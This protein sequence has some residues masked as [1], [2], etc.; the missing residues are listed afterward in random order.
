MVVLTPRARRRAPRLRLL[1][2]VASWTLVGAVGLL[3]VA[4]VLVPRS[5]GATSYVIESGSMRP[6]LPPGTLVVVRPAQ[7][8]DLTIGDVIT[9]ERGSGEIVTHRIV[10][11]KSDTSG[12]PRWRTQGDA[13]DSADASWVHPDQV[14]GKR[15]YTLPFVGNVV[16]LLDGPVRSLLLV[17]CLLGLIFYASAM[18]R[19]HRRRKEDR[20]VERR[21][22]RQQPSARSE[23]RPQVRA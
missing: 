15:W 9:F 18:S 13:N 10:K 14:L 20:E 4:V 6:T 21:R 3:L 2:Q 5:T 17:A 12:T 16:G 22:L 23:S 19:D 1:A 11:E 7:A 8:A